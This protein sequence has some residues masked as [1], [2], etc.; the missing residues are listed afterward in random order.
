MATTKIFPIHED[1][2]GSLAYIANPEKTDNGRLVYAF[3]CSEKP[4][5]AEISR[6]ER[7]GMT[8]DDDRLSGER[9]RLSEPSVTV[10]GKS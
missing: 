7:N 3:G 2:E 6:K 1:V 10:I 8:L 4:S 5:R 9:K